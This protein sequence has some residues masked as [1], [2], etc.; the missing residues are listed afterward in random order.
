M[1]STDA[2]GQSTANLTDAKFAMLKRLL[3]KRDRDAAHATVAPVDTAQYRSP[4]WLTPKISSGVC[5]HM[6]I[7]EAAMVDPEQDQLESPSAGTGLETLRQQYPPNG[8]T[9][10][11]TADGC[12]LVGT[13]S[14]QAGDTSSPTE[15]VGT[16]A[17]TATTPTNSSN[18][19]FL[20]ASRKPEDNEKGIEENKQ[21]YP[22]GKGE[23]PPP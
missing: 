8:E 7:K 15:C 19:I 17:G 2:V 9:G 21:Y 20:K 12:L 14:N 11:T 18:T 5:V 13:S 23:K 22:G 16:R 1:N 4:R 10:R 3:K 6:E